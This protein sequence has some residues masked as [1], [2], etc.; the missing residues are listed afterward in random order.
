[1][2]SGVYNHKQRPHEVYLKILETRRKN[3]TDRM[4]ENTKLKLSLWNKKNHIVPPSRKGLKMV[5][6]NT[7]KDEVAAKISLARKGKKLSAAH[8]EKLSISRTGKKQ[9][10]ETIMK[11]IRSTKGRSGYGLNGT[12]WSD[13][14]KETVYYRS[15][16]EQIGYNKLEEDPQCYKYETEPFSVLY[17]RPDGSCHLTIPDLKVYYLNGDVKIIEIKPQYMI[18]KNLLYT[19]EKIKAARNYAKK[20]GMTYAVWT[21]RELHIK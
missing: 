12:M 18:D 1:M 7:T 8:K 9:S 15:S 16:Y 11:R 3:G 5:Y 2:P 19:I 6:V 10:A 21:E 13:K 20:N 4:S 17:S 14:N